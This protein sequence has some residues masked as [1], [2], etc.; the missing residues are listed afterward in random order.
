M[1]P[2]FGSVGDGLDN[3]MMGSFSSSM[4][5]EMLNRKEWKPRVEPANA[6]FDYIETFCNG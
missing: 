5:I 2:S 3:A 6:I 1:M 4:R